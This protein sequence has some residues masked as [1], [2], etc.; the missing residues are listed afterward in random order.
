MPEH[1]KP[2]PTP[3]APATTDTETTPPAAD[4]TTTAAAEPA[5]EPV[6]E[7]SAEPVA[8][9]SAEPAAKPRRRQARGERRIAQLLDAAANVFC[10]SGYTAAST[11]AIAREAG[12]SPG[13]LY[14]FF[15]NKEAIAIE[16][17]GRLLQQWRES[18]GAALGAAN[19]QLPLNELLDAVLDPLFA[20][21]YENPAFAVLIHGPDT[22]GQITQEFN[23]I[24]DGL[25][26]RI[27]EVI[28]GYLPDA[29]PDELSKIV[30]MTFTIFKAGLDLV[31]SHEGEERQAYVTEIKKVMFRYLDPYLCAAEATDGQGNP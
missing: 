22:P 27:E 5:V 31:L 7:P 26:A 20:F 30:T 24:H 28:A 1:R 18:Q 17:G 3:P 6:N 2:E 12:V 10:T 29:P 25:L 19:L 15:P 16:L 23:S 11:N 21:N 8:K 13:T 9:H 14:Q 4:A